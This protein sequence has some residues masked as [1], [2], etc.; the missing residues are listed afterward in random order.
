MPVK[1]VSKVR[2]VREVRKAIPSK[3]QAFAKVDHKLRPGLS[4]AKTSK[5]S[6]P[7]EKSSPK[8]SGSLSAEVFNISGK[9]ERSV[10]LAKEI[11]GVK[12]N[13][14]LLA[15]A[16]HIYFANSRAHH[17]STKTRSEVRGGGAKPWRQKGTGRA[18]A[19]SR[20]SPIWVGGA[21]ALGP[22]PRKTDLALPKKMKNQALISALSAKALDSNV[23]V[24]IGLEKIS[25]KTKIVANFLQ[26]TVQ[27]GQTLF[28]TS[29]IIKNITFATRNLQKVTLQAATNLNSYEVVKNQNIFFSQEALK[30]LGNR[31]AKRNLG[32]VKK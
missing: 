9:K 6:K 5:T 14:K 29:E 13:K 31:F 19:G 16:L 30:S 15:Q 28:V 25:P 27:T 21:K 11:F 8:T 17:G 22:K 20:R 4:K 2:K 7:A 10:T 12:V 18:R 3:G 32:E 24:V 1:K 26:K 23:K